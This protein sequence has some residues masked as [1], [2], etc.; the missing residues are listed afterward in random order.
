MVKLGGRNV[1]GLRTFLALG[2]FHRH[3]LAFVQR[4][5]AFAVNRT[6]MNEH[7]LAVFLL[8]ESITF[9]IAEPFDG[10]GY[11]LCHIKHSLISVSNRT[12]ANK[13]DVTC[14]DKFVDLEA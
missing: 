10:S 8:N 1:L 2:N 4:F 14:A 5:T 11:S 13:I 3:R 7:V 12:D 9:V 6:V